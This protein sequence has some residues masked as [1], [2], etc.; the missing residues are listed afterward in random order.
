M[1]E[2]FGRIRSILLTQEPRQLVRL[3]GELYH[4]SKENQRFLQARL[5]DSSKQLP[6]YRRL[7]A[8]C[9]FPDP[10]L[11]G[12]KVRIAEAKRAVSQYQRAT[13]DLAG[14][15]DLMLIFVESGT[16]FALDL[17]Y[18][19]EDFFSAL[20]SMLS[21]ALNLVRRGNKDLLPGMQP[22]LVRLSTSARDLGWG[23]GDF[24]VDALADVVDSRQ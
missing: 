17:G 9:L 20:Q 1:K 15:V 10:L 12:S 19:E 7:V 22:R 21:R 24:V 14:T 23:Y 13:G 18:G 8:D 11:K 16:A 6:T 5:G 3:I 2:G 4:L